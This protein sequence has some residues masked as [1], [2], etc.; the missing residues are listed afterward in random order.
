[1][2]SLICAG[3]RTLLCVVLH[4]KIDQL[5]QVILQDSS[6]NCKCRKHRIL[7]ERH[8]DSR[9]RDVV[10]VAPALALF[11]S[12]NRL[13]NRVAGLIRVLPGV[14]SRRGVTATDMPAAQAHTQAHPPTTG[15]QAHLAAFRVRLHISDLIHV[16]TIW[17]F[18]HLVIAPIIVMKGCTKALASLID[19]AVPAILAVPCTSFKLKDSILAG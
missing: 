6:R 9:E 3:T 13:H 18:C 5:N 15:F 10:Y 12:S 17:R 8:R 19:L 4:G 16:L 11:K 7:I 14:F 2:I 1:M